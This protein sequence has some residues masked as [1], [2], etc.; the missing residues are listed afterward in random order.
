MAKLQKMQ[1]Y[2]PSLYRPRHNPVIRGILTAWSSEDD[3][4]VQAVQD[5]KEQLFVKTAQ[6]SFL[7][8]LGS[9]VGVFRPT[10][11]NLSDDLYRQLIPALSYAPKQ[12]IPTIKRVLEVFFGV[13]NPTIK[14]VELRPNQVDITIPSSVP[15]LRRSLKGAHHFHNYSGVITAVDTITSEIT[16]DL[17]GNTKSLVENEL[18]GAL[19]GSGDSVISALASTA[20]S[21]GVV[22]QFAAGEDLSGFS[23]SGEW[24]AAKVKNYPG[25]FMPDET[26]GY[27]L[28]NQRGFLGQSISAGTQV[29]TVIM[30]D[31][32]KISNTPGFLAF[33]FGFGT[34]E[35][36]IKYFSRPNNTTLLI[37]PG[38]T[39]QH[40]HV[41]GE[42]VNAIV[43][44]YLAPRIRG[45]DYSIYLV[46]VT[47][48]RILAQKIVESIVAAGVVINWTV[49][50]P[51]ID[52]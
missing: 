30:Q 8:A 18:Q 32:S 10:A 41:A 21:T 25:S 4:I 34:E 31:A 16:V 12:V 7:D 13:G 48:A 35:V 36:L 15:S 14:V 17:D 27:T 38:Y 45:D 2:L 47:A 28:T 37:D 51:V 5:A 11:F 33:N 42:P 46:G 44:P 22:I 43:T 29:P 26:R 23:V 3:H 40:D 24:L 52:C 20:G 6:I 9:N 1:A 49:V 19:V 39:F 50:D